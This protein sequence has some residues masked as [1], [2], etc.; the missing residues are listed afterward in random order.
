MT[1][2]E[3]AARKARWT[4]IGRGRDVERVRRSADDWGVLKTWALWSLFF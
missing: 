2:E 1:P 3:L 4:A